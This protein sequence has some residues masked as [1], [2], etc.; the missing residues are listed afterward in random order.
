MWVSGGEKRLTEGLESLFNFSY[1]YHHGTTI[2]NTHRSSQHEQYYH[3]NH[4]FFVISILRWNPFPG[5]YYLKS[6]QHHQTSLPSPKYGVMK[7]ANRSNPAVIKS[8][9]PIKI[10]ASSSA[11]NRK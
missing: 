9:R 5:V 1:Q 3:H 10:T 8:Q 11:N 4:P 6:V 2:S 7:I